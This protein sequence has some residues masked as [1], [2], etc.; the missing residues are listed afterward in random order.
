MID[1]GRAIDMRL[2]PEGVTFTY[3]VETKGSQ[4]PE[5]LDS[6]PWNYHTD[7]FGVL[8][9]IHTLVFLEYITLQEGKV[10]SIA[11]R[12]NKRNHLKDVWDPLFDGLLN[13]QDENA[14]VPKVVDTAIEELMA[15]VLENQALIQRDGQELDTFITEERKKERK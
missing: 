7:W 5:M 9:C 3:K 1:F 14:A 2:L 8:D 11:Q 6:K 12:F 4:C 15:Y 10:W 13:L